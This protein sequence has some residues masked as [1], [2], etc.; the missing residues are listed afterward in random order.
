MKA[1]VRNLL[2]STV[3]EVHLGDK[4]VLELSGTPLFEIELAPDETAMRY[5]TLCLDFDGVIHAYTSGWKG[6]NVIPDELVP[7]AIEFIESASNR[8]SIAI[9][10]TRSKY[11]NGIE[12]MQ[13]WLWKHI[14]EYYGGDRMLAEGLS[15]VIYWP[16]EKPPAFITID[17]RVHLFNGKWPSL[18]ELAAFKAW[19]K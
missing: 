5:P 12:A 11:P 3:D 19:N 15:E 17:D 13:N 1:I 6:A 18:D 7:G 9:Y 10:S 8:F 16:T 14:L 2:R 4:F